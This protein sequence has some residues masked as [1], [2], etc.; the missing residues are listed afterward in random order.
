MGLSDSPLRTARGYVFPQTARVI[1]HTSPAGPPRFLDWSVSARC[2][3][4]P[5]GIRRL[6]SVTSSPV[7]GFTH[8]RRVG[9]FLFV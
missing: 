3:H 6:L 5:R 2:T 4:S 9:Q 1:A 8:I 7:S